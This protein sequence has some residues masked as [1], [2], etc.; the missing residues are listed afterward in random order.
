MRWCVAAL[1]MVIGCLAATQAI[2]ERRVALVIGNARYAHTLPLA[3]PRND[4]ED[5]AN[6]LSR[7]GFEVRIGYDLDQ[8]KF[9]GI[10]DEFA[11][12]LEGAD[13]GLFYFAGHGLQINGK[14]FLVSTEAKLENTFLVPAETIEVD[15]I[16]RLMES[17]T[18]TNLIFLD[19][20]RNNPLTDNLRRNLAA[21][22]RTITLGRGLAAVESTSHNTLVA[23]SA[24]PGEL[25][26]DGNLRNSP[27]AAALLRHL[28]EPGLE[29]SVMFKDITADVL[30]DT[31][32][33][34]RPQQLSDMSKKFY[35]VKAEP[36][37]ATSPVVPSRLPPDPAEV[38]FWQSAVTVNECESIRA[39]LRRYPDGT[40]MDLALI[41]ERQ[42]C[43]PAS[44]GAHLQQAA[45]L[46]SEPGAAPAAVPRP[47]TVGPIA[48]A[49]ADAGPSTT[50]IS[51]PAARPDIVEI[52]RKLQME[53]K[54]V[55]CAAKGMEDDGTW[56]AGSRDAL[57]SFTEHT[58]TVAVID[59]P[60]QEALEL[61]QHTNELVC[62]PQC[63]PGTELRGGSC[64]EVR[65][66]RDRR[67]TRSPER[68]RS[69][70][71]QR[72]QR[73]HSPRGQR[74]DEPRA[75]R[76]DEPRRADAGPRLPTK[77]ENQSLDPKKGESWFY[78]GRQRCKTY[79]PMGE[80]PR[81]IC[82]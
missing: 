34:Q 17:K 65:K 8:A 29:V 35:F 42:L 81:I 53:L 25:A 21:T 58:R 13:V 56:G 75:Q 72:D 66:E 44:E 50:P 20:C 74:G 7:V 22:N 28:P 59:R 9:A 11:R 82:P 5:I 23:F 26:A 27:F 57:R 39:Y 48:K 1:F 6:T 55:G 54:R 77:E 61:V 78:L 40:F 67:A 47:S 15:A 76:S 80:T 51:Q 63:E 69:L 36:P 62:T 52:G 64:V 33:A 46:G 43:K 19:A 38:A 71:G 4:A 12:A 2:A 18:T 24:A 31:N 70:R 37:A 30:R 60:T 10:I 49:P 3:N 16:I 45:P 32:S 79:Q 14:N 41:A 73:D 68:D